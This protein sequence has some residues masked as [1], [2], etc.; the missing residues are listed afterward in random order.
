MLQSFCRFKLRRGVIDKRTVNEMDS[1][2]LG[3]LVRIRLHSSIQHPGQEKES[4]EIEATGRY[5]E[6]AGNAY[7]KYDEQQDGGEIQS[8]VKM[9]NAEALIMRR[10][11][12]TMRLP[13]FKDQDKPGEY[14]SAQANLKLLV[15]TKRLEFI[16]EVTGMGGQ[17]I[18]AYELHAQ[19]SL[20]GTYELSITYSEGIK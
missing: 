16:K 6:K 7:L 4:H 3:Q 1:K 10:G 15:R 5:I 12:I 17:F 8:T 13:F 9:G 11:A 20:L 19:G 18:V 2:G 14:G